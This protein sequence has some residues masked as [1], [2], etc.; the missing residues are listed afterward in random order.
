MAM[1]SNKLFE[2][3]KYKVVVTFE[4]LN[5]GNFID[6]EQ[7]VLKNNIVLTE[8]PIQIDKRDIILY[9][10]EKLNKY[11]LDNDIDSNDLYIDGYEVISLNECVEIFFKVND[12]ESFSTEPAIMACINSSKERPILEAQQ[13]DEHTI[14]WSWSWAGVGD[15]TSILSDFENE[16]IIANTGIGICDYI[17]SNIE[18]GKTVTRTITVKHLGNEITS[19]PISMN[20][21]ENP[22]NESVFRKYK[23][24][25]RKEDYS[26]QNLQVATR[27]KAF[28]SGIGFSDDCKIY[29]PDETKYSKRF[30]LI[31]KV[32]GIRA[33]NNI[34]YN[35]VK[36]FY[37]F[38]LKGKTHYKG[39]N[40][41]FKIKA[42]AIKIPNIKDDKNNETV[43]DWIE[44]RPYT[45]YKFDDYSNVC[46]IYLYDLFD[47][48]NEIYKD[49]RYKFEITLYEIN[50]RMEVYSQALGCNKI[51]DVENGT[52][53]FTIK[54][55]YDSMFRVRAL[56]TLKEKDYIEIYPPEHLDAL[57]GAVNG[58]FEM[59]E[60]GKKN[61]TSFLNEFDIPD[62]VFDAKYYCIIEDDK[63]TPNQAD[64]QFKFDNQIEEYTLTKGDRVTF[65]CD[66]ILED[67]KEYREFITQI[68]KGDY[69]INDNRKH[70]YRYNLDLDNVEYKKY[71]RVEMDVTTNINDITIISKDQR[72][73]LDNN[74]KL[75]VEMYIAARALQNAIS[76]WNPNIHSGYYYL[77]QE[78]YFLYNK[79]EINGK[80]VMFEQFCHKDSITVKI[81]FHVKGGIGKYKKYNFELKS[82]EDLLTSPRKFEYINN[83][84]WPKPI[85]IRDEFQTFSEE[86]I[87]FT[88]PFVCDTEVTKITS[89][90][91][92]QIVSKDTDVDVYVISYNDVYGKWREPCLIHFGEGVP[93]NVI[94]SSVIMLKFVLK[95]SLMPKLKR[96]EYIYNCESHWSEW[97]DK[98]L[99]YNISFEQEALIQ[100]SKLTTGYV[101][102][103]VY[104]LGDTKEINKLRSISYNTNINYKCKV[105]YKDSDDYSD[106]NDKY[107]PND[108]KQIDVET[109]YQSKRYVRF[110][111]EI[112][113]GNRFRYIRIIL[114]KY[115]YDGMLKEDY[116]P[117][118]GNIEI[119]EEYN[120][121]D[122]IK[123][124]EHT[125]VSSLTFDTKYHKVI[126]N[127]KLLASNLGVDQD[128]DYNK[129][130]N[131]D[132]IALGEYNQEYEL[133][134][135]RLESDPIL[136]DK[137]LLAKSK[138]VR[139][140]KELKEKSH[141]GILV[142]P[143]MGKTIELSP[144]P[145]QFSP[146][147]IQE[148]LENGTKI[149]PYTQVFFTDNSGYY[150]L[151]NIEEFESLG[152][153]TL[154][155][156]YHSIDKDSIIIRIDGSLVDKFELNDNIIEFE[157]E[158]PK[159]LYINISY[160]IKN[161]F[162]TMYDYE[163]DKVKIEL[164]GENF[165]YK[166]KSARVFYE[167]HKTSS[168]RKLEHISLNP[169]YN[170]L[171]SGY[172][173]ISDKIEPPFKVTVIPS[174][175]M[176]YANGLDTMNV[177][178]L[179]EDKYLNP[180]KNIQVNAIAALGTLDEN[181]KFTDI[182]G[183]AHFIYTS[184]TG[185][186]V[187]EI[188]AIVTE[189]V[190][191]EAKV[192]NRKITN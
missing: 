70:T 96:C 82:K 23:T 136:I 5:S 103:K 91:W 106:I 26:L 138:D 15:Y 119:E 22:K 141:I 33:S 8:N 61:M 159:G 101:V 37:R 73:Y 175:D 189:N 92:S 191:N 188:K 69:S 135:E 60:D 128:F 90:S 45:E 116:L 40:G 117:A 66:S 67:E 172:I 105:Y 64:V 7:I 65:Y 149:I 102:S 157:K 139:E 108:W 30:K 146:I 131:V 171:Y 36:F 46:E 38:M 74:K 98:N 110:K 56:S 87:Y 122:F 164:H 177:L 57:V 93:T 169:I 127:V 4:N 12:L 11:C 156:K 85:S 113:D 155:L 77:N 76:K 44:S 126:D 59:S 55:F 147:L 14:R 1:L 41:S 153:K 145:Q 107:S 42:S 100:K 184:W 72:F 17:E 176:I 160:K 29:A 109:L 27:L 120:P 137:P 50:G 150:S 187:D 95:P 185:D 31:N 170:P 21:F 16:N 80:D 49:N 142:N 3:L 75:K 32:Y 83:M 88:K 79:N 81:I 167:T 104:D 123:Y 89:I 163:N 94:P 161:S 99:S 111:I 51:L 118:I 25:V 129:I 162:V 143:Y 182:N 115:T 19:I 186:C 86:Y 178:V 190:Y 158:I 68:D 39:Y 13:I 9:I 71:K 52:I 132:F 134:Y 62:V 174:E 121:N 20:V 84:M 144:I 6:F 179:V 28:Q 152:F 97:I 166:V 125:A 10:E 53:T 148:E 173:Y 181:S 47:N 34:K 54:G 192:V 35:T 114:N 183:I 24:A 43:G 168:L 48:L 124:I 154:Y 112:S 133:V 18:T 180:I 151:I 165:L 140:D 78:E 58:D 130:V 63:T 2:E